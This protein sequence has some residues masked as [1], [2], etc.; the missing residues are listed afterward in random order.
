M[1]KR[2]PEQI[3]P[4]LDSFVVD[5]L[6]ELS[7]VSF[8]Y[9]EM[10]DVGCGDGINAAYAAQLGWTVTGVDPVDRLTDQARKSIRFVKGSLPQLPFNDNTFNLAVCTAV[11][12]TLDIADRMQSVLDIMRVVRSGGA[13]ALNCI[14]REDDTFRGGFWN[15]E[16]LRLPFD[17][18]KWEV[19]AVPEP[20]KRRGTDSVIRSMHTV[21][22]FKP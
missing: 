3:D 21:L 19:R 16:S 11:L 15:H 4:Q 12:P 22:A 14:V 13:V 9:G 10:L 8:P 7:S 1:V 17:N 18:A 6:G 5:V 20:I 2:K